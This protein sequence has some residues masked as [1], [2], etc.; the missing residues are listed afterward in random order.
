[1]YTVRN[2]KTKFLE[3]KIMF[4][5]ENSL[6]RKESRTDT[7]LPQIPVAVNLLRLRY[8]WIVFCEIYFHWITP[9]GGLKNYE[10]LQ[11]TVCL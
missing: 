7:S 11:D 1:M 3:I 10:T 9:A 2:I 4:M 6:G 8:F 5:Q